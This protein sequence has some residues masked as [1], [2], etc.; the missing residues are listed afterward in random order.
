MENENIKKC[1]QVHFSEEKGSLK[2][3]NSMTHYEL[4]LN[5]EPMPPSTE[6][7]P[8][9]DL[10]PLTPHLSYTFLEENETLP[11]IVLAKLSEKHV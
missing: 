6:K 5:T 11:V 1:L 3:Q 7:P 4:P 9:L 8:K 2:H 10:K